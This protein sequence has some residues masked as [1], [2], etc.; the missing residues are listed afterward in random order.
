MGATATSSKVE[1]VV[2]KYVRAASAHGSATETGNH[3]AANAAAR[4][5]ASAHRELV[6]LGAQE[7]LVGL[8]HEADRGVKLWAASHTLSLLPAEA[9]RVLTE[10]AQE[11]NSLIAVSAEMTLREW[12][13]SNPDVQ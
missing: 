5:I 2:A 9:K 7:S 11:P 13:K 1:K 3:K 6:G 4:T 12:K 10:L 8:L